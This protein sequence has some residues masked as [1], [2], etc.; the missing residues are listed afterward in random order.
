MII[1]DQMMSKK[2]R[3]VIYSKWPFIYRCCCIRNNQHNPGVFLELL[4][5]F[6]HDDDDYK[7]N[8]ENQKEKKGWIKMEV[9]KK[10]NGKINWIRQKQKF[11]F[12]CPSKLITFEMIVTI[13]VKIVHT[14]TIW[15]E[16]EMK[17]SFLLYKEILN[18]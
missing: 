10:K 5:F 2:E 17:F 8:V 11:F 16:L 1:S 14:H 15:H 4:P 13:I 3:K 7:S 9:S 18:Q 6:L 12:V